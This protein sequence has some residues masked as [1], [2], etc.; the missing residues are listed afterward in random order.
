MDFGKSIKII[1][2]SFFGGVFKQTGS[3]GPRAPQPRLE[4]YWISFC[5]FCQN[6]HRYPPQRQVLKGIH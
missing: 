2:K 6:V 5:Q 1:L 4:K 3:Q